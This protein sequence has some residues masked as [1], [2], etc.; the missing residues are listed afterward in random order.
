MTTVA[1]ILDKM[2]GENQPED[3]EYEVKPPTIEV[4][5][6]TEDSDNKVLSYPYILECRHN[7]LKVLNPNFKF[8]AYC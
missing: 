1:E 6:V 2:Q 3:N 7:F 8:T 4:S 5:Q